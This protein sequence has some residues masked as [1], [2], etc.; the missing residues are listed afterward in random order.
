[1]KCYITVSRI[2]RM[3]NFTSNITIIIVFRQNRTKLLTF[4]TPVDKRTTVISRV[5]L[6]LQNIFT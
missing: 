2:F 4:L 3:R 1:M 6:L 5:M